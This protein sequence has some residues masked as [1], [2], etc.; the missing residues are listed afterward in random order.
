MSQVL[1]AGG[2]VVP[3]ASWL[4]HYPR[5]WLRADLVAGT[6]AAAVVIPQAMGYATVAGLP[7]Q[8]GL[9]TCIVPMVV[10]ALLGGSRRLSIS[11]TST[12]VALTGLALTT[13]GVSGDDAVAAATTLTLLVGMALILFR[14]ARLGWIVEA[15]SEATITGLKI[16]VGVTIIADQIPNLLGISAADGGF[17]E[18]VGHAVTNVDDLSVATAVLSTATI[19]GM[20]LLRRVAPQV[21][22]PLVALTAA[23]L[24]VSLFGLDDHG[25]E[26]IPAVPTGLPIPDLPPLA[27]V[28]VL[29]PFALAIALMSYFESVTAGR[30]A[31]QPTDPPL[32]NNQEYV[33]VGAASVAGA[34]F[35]TVPPAGGFSQTQVNTGACAKTQLSELVTA[36]WAVAVAL[37][38][39][40]VLDDMPEATLGAIVVVAVAGLVSVPELA[41]LGRIDR[42]ELVV[43]VTTAVAALGTNLL[44]G[45]LVGVVLTL[46]LVL[47]AVNH[48]V[49]VEL[50][51]PPAGGELEPAR[52]GDAAVPGLL[53]LR[54]EGPLYTM[55]V[56]G[57]QAAIFAAVDAAE[58]PPQVVLV[59]VGGT[60]DTSVTVMDIFAETDQQLARKDV[61][62]WVAAL[63]T[64]ALAKARRAPAWSEWASS[65]KI[66]PT[67]AAAVAAFEHRPEPDGD[68]YERDAKLR[69]GHSRPGT[70]SN[71][72]SCRSG[73]RRRQPAAADPQRGRRR[74]AGAPVGRPALSI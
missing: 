8:V 20:V 1:S 24:L 48:P 70:A 12:I 39:A 42:V 44:I 40:P 60:A 30:I 10:Y 26:L 27:H 18:D 69:S 64:R 59:D 6:T 53:V 51:R 66:H 46:Y 31:R 2:W 19:A 32:D 35:Q 4:R 43:A 50:Q 74:S 45:V 37:V 68:A 14:F 7:V 56:R 22:G 29:L 3:A 41:R 11:T 25:V 17:L 57:V 72:G 21:P 38:L 61:A 65:G 63:P 13:A 71:S 36:A 34:F 58:P 5:R 15:V 23:I 16:G 52:L 54:V 33:A 67:V 73:R 62:L 28:D 47:R 9:Y 49:V 55:N